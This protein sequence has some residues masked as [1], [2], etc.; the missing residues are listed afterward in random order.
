MSIYLSKRKSE[1]E[2][3][4]PN[5]EGNVMGIDFISAEGVH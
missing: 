1:L 4:M 2:F 5:G 3:E